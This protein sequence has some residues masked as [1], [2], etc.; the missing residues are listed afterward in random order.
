M[1]KFIEVTEITRNQDAGIEHHKK[2]VLNTDQILFFTVVKVGEVQIKLTDGTFIN[3][4]TS[5]NKLKNKL[6]VIKNM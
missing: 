6:L 4:S 5:Y 1:M 2:Y 3:A